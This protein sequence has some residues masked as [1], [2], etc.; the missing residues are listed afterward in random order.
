M[1]VASMSP[2]E[3]IFYQRCTVCHGPRDPAQFTPRQWQG[4]TQSMFPRAGLNEEEKKLVREF[5]MQNAKP[6]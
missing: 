6:E 2:G 1:A 3:K 5:L 4:I